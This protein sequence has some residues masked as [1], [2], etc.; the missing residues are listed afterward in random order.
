MKPNP[1]ILGGIKDAL[2]HMS[3]REKKRHISILGRVFTL[4]ELYG[5][6]K[7][8][9]KVGHAFETMLI[10]NTVRRLKNLRSKT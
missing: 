1:A 10:S 9:T 2:E 5:E 4:E 7:R 6:Y 3:E 8:G